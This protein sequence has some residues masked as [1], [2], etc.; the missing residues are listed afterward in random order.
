MQ[1]SKL[2]AVP[3]LA[4]L[5][6]TFQ[7]DAEA[8]GYRHY[9]RY[10]YPYAYWSYWGGYAYPYFYTGF[11]GPPYPYAYYGPSDREP[12]HL[13]IEVK[14][15]EAEVYVDGYFTGIVDEFDGFLQR[16]HLTPGTHEIVIYLEGHRSIREKLYLG[17]GQSYKI[18]RVLE[19]LA[20][21]ETSE[22]PKEPETAPAT[23]APV[24]PASEFGALELRVRPDGA[25]ILID[26]AVWP[27]SGFEPLVVNLAAGRHHVEIRVAGKAPFTA[28]ILVEAGKT[29]TLNVMLP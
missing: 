7:A 15:V 10:P 13:R 1:F 14:P 5:F 21:G 22:R 16:L 25:E 8:H 20:P 29:T 26:G 17:P 9:Y 4:L 28:D 12:G 23:T 27:S 11:Y 18:R 2:P 6:L 3:L 19:P 24:A